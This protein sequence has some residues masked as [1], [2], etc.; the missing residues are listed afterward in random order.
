LH[1]GHAGTVDAEGAG[2]AV[3]PDPDEMVYFTEDN[4]GQF[5]PKLHRMTHHYELLNRT[6]YIDAKYIN[7]DAAEKCPECFPPPKMKTREEIEAELIRAQGL[8]TSDWPAGTRWRNDS[9]I[10][11]LRWVRGDYDT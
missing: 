2:E 3:K 9:W 1:G 11:A 4:L 10:N 8:S 7:S 5:P 6:A